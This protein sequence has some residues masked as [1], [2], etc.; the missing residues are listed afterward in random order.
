MNIEKRLKYMVGK[1][2]LYNTKNYLINDY[3]IIEDMILL[4]T[5][6]G[7][8]KFSVDEAQKKFTEFIPIDDLPEVKP[9]NNG[10][11]TATSIEIY[12]KKELNTLVDRLMENIEKVKVDK[13]FVWQ[14]NAINKS[15]TAITNLLKLELEI[16]RYSSI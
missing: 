9:G 8:V 4:S 12:R 14:A 3:T 10:N 7:F 11:G 13:D 2:W 5:N 16:K 6:F 1:T 15:I